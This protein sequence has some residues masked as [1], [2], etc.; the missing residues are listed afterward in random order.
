[1]K[2][3]I[4]GTPG[5]SHL[6]V[7]KIL[8]ERLSCNL[9]SAKQIV[10]DVFKDSPYDLKTFRTHSNAELDKKINS[11]LFD[12]IHN[13]NDYIADAILASEFSV[14]AT[15]VF[16]YTD[17]T[18]AELFAEANY[19]DY[20]T[21]DNLWNTISCYEYTDY[22]N[23]DIYINNTGLTVE[24]VVDVIIDAMWRGKSGIFAPVSCVLPVTMTVPNSSKHVSPIHGKFS[25]DFLFVSNEV[26]TYAKELSSN[27]VLHIDPKLEYLG[28]N[29]DIPDPLYYEEWFKTTQPCDTH[30]LVKIMLYHYCVDREIK[31]IHEEFTRLSKNGDVLDTLINAGYLK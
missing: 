6:G 8:A 2:I 16:L 26:L 22:R 19:C 13:S 14:D 4:S 5:S 27:T 10:D 7:S 21:E 15:R 31:N 28:I 18:S 23:Y 25:H 3:T 20:M 29:Y 11:L 30:L 1:M 9:V 17:Y 12:A 24:D